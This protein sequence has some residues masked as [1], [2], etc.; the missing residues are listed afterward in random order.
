MEKIE[1][2][3]VIYEWNFDRFGKFEVRFW[4]GELHSLTMLKG[5]GGAS[6]EGLRSTDI[7]FLRCI[8]TALSELLESPLIKE[9]EERKL[10]IEYRN[11][12]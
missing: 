3:Q 11:R 8:H 12:Y 1:N 10:N 4:N 9:I 7:D 2:K 5:E 6:E